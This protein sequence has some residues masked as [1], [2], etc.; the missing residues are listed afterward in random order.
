CTRDRR[1]ADRGAPEGIPAGPY[2]FICAEHRSG[3]GGGRGILAAGPRVVIPPVGTRGR[4]RLVCRALR[5]SGRSAAGAES[6]PGHRSARAFFPALHVPRPPR[7]SCPVRLMWANW[8]RGSASLLR[9]GGVI[10]P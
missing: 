5:R 8:W 7:V 4:P 1:G 6:G 2:P 10:L 3:N 9:G